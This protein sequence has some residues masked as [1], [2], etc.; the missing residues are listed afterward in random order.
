MPTP[1]AVVLAP[2][3]Q[4]PAGTAPVIDPGGAVLGTTCLITETEPWQAPR[5]SAR[6][7]A[8]ACV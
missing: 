5:A 4:P 8:P 6:R 3:V 2:N 7:A 1:D